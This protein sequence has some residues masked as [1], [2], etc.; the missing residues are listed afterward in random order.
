MR[1]PLAMVRR[2]LRRWHILGAILLLAACWLMYVLLF[3]LADA[4]LTSLRYY[5]YSERICGVLS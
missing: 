3:Q 5:I 1:L 4:V 2:H